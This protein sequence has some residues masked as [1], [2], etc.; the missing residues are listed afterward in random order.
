MGFSFFDTDT[1]L[2]RASAACS[3]SQ[4]K[5][6]V[7]TACLNCGRC[8]AACPIGLVP[9]KLYRLIDSGQYAEAMAN[10]DGLQGVRMLRLCLPPYLPLVHGM[11]TGKKLGR[12]K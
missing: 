5:K 2:T 4:V 6:V 12:K 7:T 10:S 1:P 9:A 3:H 8:V 11:K